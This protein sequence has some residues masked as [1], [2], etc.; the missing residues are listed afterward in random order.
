MAALECDRDLRE[1]FDAGVSQQS[2]CRLLTLFGLQPAVSSVWTMVGVAPAN[3][4][5]RYSAVRPSSSTLSGSA[6]ARSSDVTHSSLPLDAASSS[7]ADRTDAGILP[8]TRRP[9]SLVRRRPSPS[10]M[11]WTM[12]QH[13]ERCDVK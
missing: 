8:P 7:D 6:P 4:T 2:S 1:K 3:S 12:L 5:R 9:R 13:G 11:D 10:R